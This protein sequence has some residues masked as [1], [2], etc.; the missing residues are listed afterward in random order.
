MKPATRH[1]L[2]DVGGI[3]RMRSVESGHAR[4]AVTPI[5]EIGDIDRMRSVEPGHARIAE[6][7]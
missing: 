4:I 6:V 3:D 7:P 2:P 1:S 5:A